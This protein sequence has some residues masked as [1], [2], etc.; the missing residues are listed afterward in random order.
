VH[1]AEHWHELSI[2]SRPPPTVRDL[3]QCGAAAREVT[4]LVQ[5]GRTSLRGV[6]LLDRLM[7][8]GFASALYA[9]SPDR[10]ARELGRI[11]FLLDAT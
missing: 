3:L 6:A 2:T 8:G 1:A 7:C 5:D 10:L 4:R 11:R 9:G